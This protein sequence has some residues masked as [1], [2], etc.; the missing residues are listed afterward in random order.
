MSIK[1]TT[2][3]VIFWAAR[4]LGGF[5]IAI[6]M[7]S[8]FGDIN[9]F[10]GTKDILSFICFPMLVILG[11]LLAYRSEGLGG[12]LSII[13][14]IGLHVLR[15]DLAGVVEINLFAI[16]GILYLIYSGFRQ[17]TY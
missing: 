15:N 5:S 2:V 8:M 4:I 13:G 17:R 16:P 6:L 1:P 3:K 11:L 7:Y 14:M 10:N 12:L 9:Q